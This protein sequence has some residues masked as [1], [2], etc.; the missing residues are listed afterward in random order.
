MNPSVKWRFS[1]PDAV[2]EFVGCARRRSVVHSMR[3]IDNVGTGFSCNG[4]WSINAQIIIACTAFSQRIDLIRAQYVT[5]ICR[6]SRYYISTASPLITHKSWKCIS[7]FQYFS[8]TQTFDTQSKRNLFQYHFEKSCFTI[9][10]FFSLLCCN[11]CNTVTDFLKI[12]VCIS[13][14]HYNANKGIITPFQK[15]S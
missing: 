11:S 10:F 5:C 7:C 6:Y 15:V 13:K 9:W 4:S 14:T 12:S 8:T 2:L 1:P 3:P